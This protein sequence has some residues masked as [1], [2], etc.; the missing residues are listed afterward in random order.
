MFWSDRNERL[1]SVLSKNNEMVMLY[2]VDETKV[3][4]KTFDQLC[5]NVSQD[6]AMGHPR[7][8]LS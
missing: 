3:A 4:V 1:I 6:K 5:S 7:Y 2:T 8:L